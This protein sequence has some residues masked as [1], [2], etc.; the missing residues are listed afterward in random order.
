MNEMARCHRAISVWRSPGRGDD[1]TDTARA[2]LLSIPLYRDNEA[3]GQ[4]IIFGI[5]YGGSALSLSTSVATVNLGIITTQNATQ[6]QGG[7]FSDIRLATT[8]ENILVPEPGTSLL[9]VPGLA[10]LCRRRR[11]A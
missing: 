6:A 8:F 1:L 11:T 3:T 4:R 9:L 2:A 5:D 10:F 7:T